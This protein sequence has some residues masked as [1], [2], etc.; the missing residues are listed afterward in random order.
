MC[1]G[2]DWSIVAELVSMDNAYDQFQDPEA[3]EAQH[4]GWLHQFRG[5]LHALQWRKHTEETRSALQTPGTV[6]PH[7]HGRAPGEASCMPPSP[8]CL[9]AV[10]QTQHVLP[11]SVL[12]LAAHPVW[13]LYSV[14]LL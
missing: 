14:H 3:A 1:A 12:N 11:H 5:W 10:C 4:V 7:S 9:V 6:T 8:P 2:V 13:L